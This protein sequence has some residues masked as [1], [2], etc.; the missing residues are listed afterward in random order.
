MALELLRETTEMVKEESA[1]RTERMAEPTEPLAYEWS[2][3]FGGAYTHKS[4][5]KLSRLR[6]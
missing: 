1:S 3:R 5:M 4:S 6:Q 2:V